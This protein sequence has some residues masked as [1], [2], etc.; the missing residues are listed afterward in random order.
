MA[1]AP[2]LKAIKIQG[3]DGEDEIVSLTHVVRVCKGRTPD[4]KWSIVFHCGK[5]DWTDHPV[6]VFNSKSTRDTVFT[7]LSKD[8]FDT[9]YKQSKA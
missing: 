5:T 6:A 1:V 9:V 8:A 2:R 3:V 7:R 4:K